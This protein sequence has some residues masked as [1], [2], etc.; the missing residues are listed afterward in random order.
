[1][2]S[3]ALFTLPPPL[4]QRA[5]SLLRSD[6]ALLEIT[7]QWIPQQSDEA[8]KDA[9][10]GLCTLFRSAAARAGWLPSPEE[11]TRLAWETLG[12]GDSR[13]EDAWR[14]TQALP[15]GDPPALHGGYPFAQ[16]ARDP[17]PQPL[18]QVQDLWAR[19]DIVILAAPPGWGKSYLALDA[20][21][22]LA[23]GRPLWGGF[24]VPAPGRVAYLDAEMT[25]PRF[26][27]RLNR[28]LEGAKVTPNRLE[29]RA[30]VWSEN[31][32]RLDEEEG[33]KKAL[34]RLLPFA[35]EHGQLDLVILDTLRRFLA[36]D[37]S[38][39][40]SISRFFDAIHQL[41][42][43]LGGP[44]FLLPHHVRKASKLDGPDPADR[45]RGSS[46]LRG[47]PDC[48]LIV[49]AKADGGRFTLLNP[50]SRERELDP[51]IIRFDGWN[52]IPSQ[53]D[54]KTPLKLIHEGS[55][56]TALVAGHLLQEDIARYLEIQPQH[57]A[58][59]PQIIQ[60]FQGRAVERSVSRALSGLKTAGVANRIRQP[61]G[62]SVW[63]LLDRNDLLEPTD[64]N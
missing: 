62:Q 41:R 4:S 25:R 35:M 28:L 34:R 16:L 50:K 21:V 58:E 51:F 18:W 8:R 59:R 19:G 13:L 12:S 54:W 31:G 22:S 46:D 23:V 3:P 24:V 26:Q 9:V 39:S 1:M 29:E 36:G 17:S 57:R 14:L 27:R 49:D 64:M 52:G 61:G 38:D 53:E 32:F 55:A 42:S 30:C 63:F 7:T 47:A 20:A 45:L 40:G 43:D 15:P 56:A 11:L 48:V 37:E 2:A 5:R 44:T 33:Y 6:P 10:F 60:A